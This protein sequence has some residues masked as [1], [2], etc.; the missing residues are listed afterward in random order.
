MFACLTIMYLQPPQT[1]RFLT[2]AGKG[3]GRTISLSSPLN[4]NIP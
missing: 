1:G 2:R 4:A 3:C